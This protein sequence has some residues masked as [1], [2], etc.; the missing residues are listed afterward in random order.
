ML[1]RQCRVV[2]LQLPQPPPFTKRGPRT[3]TEAHQLLE[4]VRAVLLG[5]HP[6]WRALENRQLRRRTGKLGY[7]LHAT[8]PGTDYRHPLPGQVD[9]V[10]PLSGV[11][12]VARE[13]AEPFDVGVSRGTEQSDRADHNV[14]D[15]DAVRRR[16]WPRAPPSAALLRSSPAC[17]RTSRGSGDGAGRS[18]R[19][20]SRG[21]QGS[22]VDT[23][24]CGSMPDSA[25]MRTSTSDSGCRT[26][27]PDRCSAARCRRHRPHAR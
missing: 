27:R 13:V 26:P 21:R 25:R 24:T 2:V 1:W 12:Q 8:C 11:H 19:R 4:A 5:H 9:G 22:P 23:R 17:A 14:G 15:N 16:H 6:R 3:P 10:I 20:R 7:D 18:R